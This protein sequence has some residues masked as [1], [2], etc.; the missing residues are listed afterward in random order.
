MDQAKTAIPCLKVKPKSLS[1][2]QVKTHV[3]AVKVRSF[4]SEFKANNQGVHR[5][6]DSWPEN[7]G[8]D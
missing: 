7:E 1:D 4:H 3:T 6:I 5:I 2:L 8:A